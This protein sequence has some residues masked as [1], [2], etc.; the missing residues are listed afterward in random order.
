MVAEELGRADEALAV[1]DQLGEGAVV[2]LVVEDARR[3]GGDQQR[4]EGPQADPDR[5]DRDEPD[6]RSVLSQSQTFQGAPPAAQMSFSRTA[7]L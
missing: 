7:S 1:G 6:G 4:L 3:P 2:G 5:H